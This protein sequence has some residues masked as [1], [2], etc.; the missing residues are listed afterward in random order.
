MKSTLLIA[1]FVGASLCA[2]GQ[3]KPKKESGGGSYK[4][5]PTEC[6][7]PAQHEAIKREIDSNIR[8]IE[9]QKKQKKHK[10]RSRKEAKAKTTATALAWPIEQASS[11]YFNIDAISNYVDH[12]A[13]I[14]SLQDW[15][16]GTRTYDL[17]S[18]YNHS[19]TDIFLWP[20]YWNQMEDENAKIVAAAPGTIVGK[21]DGYFDKNCSMGSSQWNAVYVK[22]ADGSVA[23][24]GHM[25][26]NSLTTKPIGAAV[27]AGEFL[28]FVGSSGSSTGP[29]LHF[30]LQYASGAVVDPYTGPCNAGTTWWSPAQAYNKSQIN[31]L[32]THS[33][34]VIF[35]PCPSPDVTNACDTFRPGD[36][37]YYY[38]YYRDQISGQVSTFSIKRPNGSIDDTWSYAAS[39]DYVAAYRY[40]S[41]TIPMTAP[42]GEWT[43]SVS[44]EGNT[45]VHKYYIIN[46][47]GVD[48][49]ARKSLTI[50][51]NP[52]KDVIYFGNTNGINGIE[53]VDA[54]GKLLLTADVPSGELNIASLP[55]GVYY[56][57]LWQGATSHMEQLVKL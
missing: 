48:A 34:A 55:A 2:E 21:H 33:S 26:K 39:T 32:M 15:N 18:G 41:E 12:D 52:A 37:I 10:K 1:L 29:H 45:Y 56:V 53:L 36:M 50:Y 38:A 11:T 16:C 31:A 7:T 35:S 8:V 5:T 23:W 42:G 46:T 51:P 25:K 44:Y 54:M 30:E 20:F 57:R 43:L 13:S 19:G 22:H 6:I 4:P 24:Y 9:K 27:S 47:A 17:G 49:A 28:G 3:E 14:G 40:W